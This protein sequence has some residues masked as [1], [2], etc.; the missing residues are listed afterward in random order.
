MKL[1]RAADSWGLVCVNLRIL[2]VHIISKVSQ[3]NVYLQDW[4]CCDWAWLMHYTFFFIARHESCKSSQTLIFYCLCCSHWPSF[5]IITSR[6][7][8]K[9]QSIGHQL[10]FNR[11]QESPQ[12]SQ[13]EHKPLGSIPVRQ[14]KEKLNHK[15]LKKRPRKSLTWLMLKKKLTQI[16]LML[17]LKKKVIILDKHL[18]PTLLW[19]RVLLT[20][21]QLFPTFLQQSWK[22]R[23]NKSNYLNKLY[24]TYNKIINKHRLTKKIWKKSYTEVQPSFHPVSLAALQTVLHLTLPATWHISL[25]TMDPSSPI[26]FLVLTRFSDLSKAEDVGVDKLAKK[27]FPVSD[28]LILCLKHEPN[29]N[30]AENKDNVEAKT[31]WDGLRESKTKFDAVLSNFKITEVNPALGSPVC[32]FPSS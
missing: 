26:N 20:N 6:L 19:F 13:P 1:S 24:M 10:I 21:F 22:K 27:L 16:L 14:P 2:W 31:A 23:M 12:P 25:P 29:W 9:H 30:D 3:V 4:A 8:S 5:P 28:T 17:N 11:D 7:Q 18:S 32:I 15:K